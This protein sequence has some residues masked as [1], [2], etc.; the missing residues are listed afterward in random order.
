MLHSNDEIFQFT[1]ETFSLCKI[2]LTRCEET[3]L[4][5]LFHDAFQDQHI[6][7]LKHSNEDVN[8]FAEHLSNYPPKLILPS[9]K[10][11]NVSATK[12]AWHEINN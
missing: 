7:A 2:Y 10:G 12:Y 5:S 9:V 1:G 6:F 8:D 4:V 11:I 3:K